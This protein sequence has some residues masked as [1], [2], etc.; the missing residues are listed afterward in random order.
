MNHEQGETK[1]AVTRFLSP[2]IVILA[3]AAFHLLLLILDIWILPWGY[4]HKIELPCLAMF[5]CQGCLLGFWAA[6]G[7][8][9]MPWRAAIVIVCI[10]VWESFT[11]DHLTRAT[12]L[13]M[14]LLMGQAFLVM[15]FLLLARLVGLRLERANHQHSAGRLQFSIAQARSWMTAFAVFLAVAHYLADFFM[16]YWYWACLQILC[17][18]LALATMWFVFGTT[19]T[20]AHFLLLVAVVGIGMVGDFVVPHWPSSAEILGS[21]AVWATVS[22]LVVCTGWASPDLVLALWTLEG[23]IVLNL[24]PL[25]HAILEDYALPWHGIHGVG[26]WARVLENGLR[27]AKNTD[28]KVEI[29]QLFAVFH[30]SRRAN[31]GFDDGHGLRGAELAAELRGDFFDLPDATFQ[32][33]YEA[34]AT[35]RMA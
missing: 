16:Q 33:L 10:G 9:A 22:L 25:V 35:T 32:L 26:H 20:V 14:N 15:G 19:G 28:A 5:A 8:N 11:K 23:T 21:E 29:V 1:S 31:E 24:H 13:G 6:L 27:L 17:T 2:R 30:D 3:L 34:C 18:A 4:H 12:V 7:G